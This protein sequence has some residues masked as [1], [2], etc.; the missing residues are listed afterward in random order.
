LLG[1]KLETCSGWPIQVNAGDVRANT[2]L[3]WPM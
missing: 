3:N 1:L 2:F